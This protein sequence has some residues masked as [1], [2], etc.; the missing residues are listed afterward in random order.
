[1]DIQ[2]AD[3]ARLGGAIQHEHV[4]PEEGSYVVRAIV[5]DDDGVAVEIRDTVEALP[6]NQLPTGSLTLQGDT[7][8]DAPLAVRIQ[9]SGSAAA[10]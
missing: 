7:E 1:M 8:G 10:K 9:T 4:F 2:G 6:P 3:F 5:Y